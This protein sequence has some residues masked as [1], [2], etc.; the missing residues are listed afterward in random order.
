VKGGQTYL[1]TGDYEYYHYM[2]DKFDDNGWGCAYRSLQ[3]LMSWFRLQHFTSVPV[4]SHKDI[5]KTLVKNGVRER[6]FI[7]SKDWIGAT[8]V[9]EVLNELIGVQSKI[10]FVANGADLVNQGRE[11]ARHF[12]TQGT[13][14]MMGGGKLAYTLLG[15]DW[16]EQT[17][18]IQFLILDP[19][20]TGHDDL[21]IIQDK[22][23]CGWKEGSLFDK[24]SFY[25][26]CMPQRPKFF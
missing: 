10:H 14:I 20:F 5:Q 8:E 19:H 3:T 7:G 23:W 6:K 15:I 2:Q 22:G 17:G 25:N 24:N 21:G 9:S 4:P 13:P 11:L 12:A 16:N 18:D 1:I 26:L